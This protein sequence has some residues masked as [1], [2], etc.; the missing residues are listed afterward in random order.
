MVVDPA[1]VGDRAIVS[2][3]LLVVEVLSAWGRIRD[4]RHKR[5]LYASAGCRH[6]WIVD[7]DEPG[8]TVLRLAGGDYQELAHVA[9]DD[10]YDA[11]QPVKVRVVTS[12]LVR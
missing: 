3:P 8:L 1:A 11:T 6:Y 10:A 2:A 12:Q 9:G 4:Q 5:E 7:P